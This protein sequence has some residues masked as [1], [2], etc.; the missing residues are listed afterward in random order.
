MGR[1]NLIALASQNITA[2]CDVDWDFAGKAFERLSADI[3]HL[4]ARI[5]QPPASGQAQSQTRT[6][7]NSSTPEQQLANMKRLYTEHW[8]K[9]KRYKDYREMLEKQKDI[10]AVVVATS[11]HMHT[12]SPSPQWSSQARLRAKAAHLVRSRSPPTRKKS[13]GDQ[14]RHANGQP[15]PLFRRSPPLCRI[16]SV[17]RI[18]EVREIHVGPTV[19]SVSGRKAFLGRQLSPF[20]RKVSSGTARASMRA[21]LHRSLGTTRSGYALVE[22]LPRRRSGRSVPPIYHPFNW[23]GWV[24]WGCGQSATW[25]AHLLD[26]S[27]WRSSL[28]CPQALKPFAHRSTKSL[29]NATQTF[30]KFPAR[31]KMP[32]VSLTWY[33]GGL[34][35]PSRKNSAKTKK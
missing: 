12:P 4:Q 21:L 20:L 23:R 14:G 7:L 15:G 16:H 18:G 9:A 27:L 13:Q 34:L 6:G 29:P 1:A 32:A 2:L 24:D 17:W 10:D 35:P 26:V 30:F 19:P 5:N 31:G 28:G 8:Q 25:A 22:S 33:D 11:D 3:E